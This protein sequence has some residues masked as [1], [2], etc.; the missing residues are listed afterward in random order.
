[1]DTNSIQIQALVTFL[2]PFLIQLLKKNR[3][4]ALAW[5]DQAKPRVCVLTNGVTALLTAMGIQ[6]ECAP[7]HF[8]VSWPDGATLVRGFVTFV[9]GFALQHALYEGFWRHLVPSPSNQAGN[10]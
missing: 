2:T 5:I 3:A 1:V 9:L 8:T 7:H 6:L 4:Q 10:R